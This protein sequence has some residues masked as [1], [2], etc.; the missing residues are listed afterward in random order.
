MPVSNDLGKSRS[1]TIPVIAGGEDA[2][3]YTSVLST[4]LTFAMNENSKTI[5]IEITE[6]TTRRTPRPSLSP[7][8]VPAVQPSRTEPPPID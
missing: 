8:P 4:M 3:Q 6:D 2:M 5:S 1:T 7:S